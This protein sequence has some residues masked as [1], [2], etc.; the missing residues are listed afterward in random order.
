MYK[1]FKWTDKSLIRNNILRQ[2]EPIQPYVFLECGRKM[3]AVAFVDVGS[4]I[5]AYS[6]FFS[7]IP[8]V[9]EIIA[10][11]A[12]PGTFA[13]LQ[14]NIELNMLA[15]KITALNMAVSDN[16]GKI[17]FGVVGD[18]SGANGA[19]DTSIHNKF[20][21]KVELACST[22]DKLVAIRNASLCLKI[23]VE[24]HEAVVLDGATDVLLNNACIVQ[25][26]NYEITGRDPN[27]LM[28]K[29]LKLGYS[30][31]FNIGPDEY[32]SNRE[33]SAPDLVKILSNASSDLIKANF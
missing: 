8:S 16:V 17:T 10:I 15:P 22:L 12:V 28:N 20:Q 26:E 2:F 4:N 9:R 25:I 32:Y 23:D 27:I 14:K 33:I 11:E 21:D 3:N 18:L 7:S 24:G 30:K 1:S 13:E 5:G 6:L 31:L 19:L 29:F